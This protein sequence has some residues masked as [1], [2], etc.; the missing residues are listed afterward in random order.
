MTWIPPPRV[1]PHKSSAGIM[2]AERRSLP[3][4]AYLK[5]RRVAELP[6]I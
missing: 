5:A 4:T 6:N 1:S 3:A 2:N